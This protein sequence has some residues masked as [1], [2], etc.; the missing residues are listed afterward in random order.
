[1]ILHKQI[2]DPKKPRKII[3]VLI[4]KPNGDESIEDVVVDLKTNPKDVDKI[5]KDL[6]QKKLPEI[7]EPNAK[8]I[9]K[10]IDLKPGE[11]ETTEEFETDTEMA[12]K[13]LEDAMKKAPRK[14]TT[15]KKDPL[16]KIITKI[17]KRKPDGKEMVEEF[18]EDPKITGREI[19]D[20]TMGKTNEF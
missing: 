12:R 19:G 7:K 20:E 4:Q 18:V 5:S 9:C 6:L 1:M 3:R 15:K 2:D 13:N 14:K 16:G 10:I 8:I 11:E 17:F